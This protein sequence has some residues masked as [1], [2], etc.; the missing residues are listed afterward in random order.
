MKLRTSLALAL[1]I[2]ACLAHAEKSSFVGG[3]L[4]NPATSQVLENSVVVVDGERIAAV[5]TRKEMAVPT[6]SKWIDSGKINSF[7]PVTS[8]RT[9]ISFNRVDYSRDRTLSI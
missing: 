5:G 8:T 2:V 7:C 3:T 6:G 1:S 4:I 9:F